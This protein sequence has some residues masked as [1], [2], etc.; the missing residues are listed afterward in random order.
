VR[1]G[2]ICRMDS[3]GLA[4]QTLSLAR[5]LQ[6]AR[7]LLVDRRPF[8]GQDVQQHPARFAEFETHDQQRLPH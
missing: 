8:N 6:P 3:G 1:L 5:M 7:V 2:P 4:W